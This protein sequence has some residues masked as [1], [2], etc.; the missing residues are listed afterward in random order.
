MNKHRRSFLQFVTWGAAVIAF[1]ELVACRDRRPSYADEIWGADQ[2][3]PM[4][5][6]PVGQPQR[7]EYYSRYRVGNYSGGFERMFKHNRITA[8]RAPSSLIPDPKQIRYR[9]GFGLR[10]VGDYLDQWPVTGL[11]IARKGRILHE[12]YRFGRSAEMRLTSWSMAKSVTSLLFGIAIDKG[13]IK[14]LDDMPQF[15][16]PSLQG[17]LH[18]QIKIR[19]LLNMSSGANVLHERDPPRIDVPAFLGQASARTL[20]TDLEQVVR[21]CRDV[22]EQPGIRYNYNELCP[23]TLGMVLRAVSQMSLAQFTQ[24]NLWQTIGAESDATWLTDSLGKEYNCVG[25]A[26][27]LRDWARLGQLVAQRGEMEGRQIVSGAWID[28]CATHGSQDAQVR[29]GVMQPDMGYKNFF[30]HPRA[31][32]AWLMMNGHHGQRVLVDRASQTVLVQTA[33]GPEGAWL[34]EFFGLFE[35]AIE[36]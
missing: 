27:R 33:V 29:F 20:G 8:S 18:G 11:L 3:Y 19:H 25:F 1:P 10:S 32:G 23:L 13:L 9:W 28:D 26:A 16:V 34:K 35:A 24:Q 4:G 5:W 14:S 12:E 21:G 15:Y 36:S 6:G 22:M 17:T 2:A 31:N 30:W 7:W